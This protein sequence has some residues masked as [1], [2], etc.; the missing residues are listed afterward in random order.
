MSISQQELM[1][2]PLFKQASADIAE[3]KAAQETQ[4]MLEQAN[5]QTARKQQVDKVL[6]QY[7]AALADYERL[8]VETHTALGRVWRAVQAYAVLTQGAT[9]PNYYAAVFPN[10]H[11]PTLVPD[12]RPFANNLGPFT[13]TRA[14]ME[15]YQSTLGKTW[16]SA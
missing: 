7:N 15:G 14:A 16:P 5:A 12:P 11:L 2:H 10:I 3:S 1:N 6:E 13:T 4:R 9:P 8:R